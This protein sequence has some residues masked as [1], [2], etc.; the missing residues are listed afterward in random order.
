MKQDYKIN[1]NGKVVIELIADNFKHI[2]K[3]GKFKGW[4]R[5]E[6]TNYNI[7]FNKVDEINVLAYC[8]ICNELNKALY[9]DP[10][11]E[12]PAHDNEPICYK[13]CSI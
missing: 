8:P 3:K 9:L 11:D 12:T 2:G 7:E 10:F 1:E 5:I 4:I 13:C 6:R